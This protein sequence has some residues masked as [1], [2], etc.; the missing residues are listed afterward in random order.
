[1]ATNAL[2]SILSDA[3]KSWF[4]EFKENIDKVLLL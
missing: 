1:M 2:I 4:T 3:T